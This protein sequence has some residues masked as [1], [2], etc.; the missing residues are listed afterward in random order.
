MNIIILGAGQVGSTVAENLAAYDNNNVTVIDLDIHLLDSLKDRLD[1]RTVHG[2]GAHPDIL[3]KAGGYDADLLL[4]VT[5]KDETNIV[6]CQVAYTIFKVPQKIARVRHTA[7]LNHPKLFQPADAP[8]DMLISPEQMVTEYTTRLVHMP[9]AQHV[10]DFADGIARMVGVKADTGGLMIGHEIQEI[11]EL[12]PGIDNRIVTVFRHGRAMDPKADL[13]LQRGDMVYFISATDDAIEVMRQLRKAEKPY[14]RVMIGG[15]GNIGLLLAR[16]LEQSYQVKLIERDPVRARE[17]ADE[18]DDCIVLVGDV[19][20]KELLLDENIE[21][22]DVFIAVTSADE[23]NILSSMLAKRLGVN[24]VMTLINR[25]DY[26][27]LVE[28]VI[29]VAISPRQVTISNLLT[30]VRGSDVVTAH[31][32][33]NG[34]SEVVEVIPHGS[35]DNSALI[36]KAI[37]NIKLPRGTHIVA[38]VR[39]ESVLIAHHDLEIEADDHVILFMADRGRSAEVEKMFSTGYSSLWRRH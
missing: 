36:G 1:I 7:Y 19:A 13:K 37:A 3:E 28:D 15:G 25:P 39:G 35:A 38:L 22:T 8:V 21:D 11:R 26:A 5:D 31:A 27:S 4:A 23:A 24:K 17:L 34:V 33:R 29:D 10:V 9:G 2:N 14:K 12:L 30:R 20:D 16:E 6:S 18:L 32:L